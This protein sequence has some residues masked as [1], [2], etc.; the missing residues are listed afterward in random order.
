M[1]NTIKDKQFFLGGKDKD[2]NLKGKAIFT[3][4]VPTAFASQYDTKPHYT[5][6]INYKAASGNYRENWFIN[7]LSGPD[8]Q[9]DYT[10]VGML[11]NGQVQLSK[12]SK[13]TKDSW[14]VKILNRVLACYWAG[15]QNKIMAAGWNVHHEG[16]CCVCGKPLTRPDSINAGIGPDCATR[17]LCLIE[18]V[19]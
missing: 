9:S 7:L 15:E 2:G 5:Y 6:K 8:N 11:V 3:I 1:S 18:T 19:V 17:Q 16:A 13:Y 14:P 12:A 10:Y 4:E